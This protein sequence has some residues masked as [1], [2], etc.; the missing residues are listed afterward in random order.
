MASSASPDFAPALS[1][2]IAAELHPLT[3]VPVGTIGKVMTVPRQSSNYAGL[4]GGVV[5]H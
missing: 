3:K 4:R 5:V 2:K 1:S